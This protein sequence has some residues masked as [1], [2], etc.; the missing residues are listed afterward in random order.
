MTKVFSRFVFY[1]YKK[2]IKKNISYA[3]LKEFFLNKKKHKIS[4]EISEI[5]KLKYHKTS[6]SSGMGY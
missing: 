6:P 3:E 2:S 5:A 4:F 1:L